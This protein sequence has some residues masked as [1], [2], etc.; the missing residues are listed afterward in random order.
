MGLVFALLVGA[1]EVAVFVAMV[2]L[3]SVRR[4]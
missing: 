3:L 4:D 1:P 2:L